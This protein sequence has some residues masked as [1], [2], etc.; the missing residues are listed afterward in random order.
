MFKSLFKWVAEPLSGYSGMVD[1][2]TPSITVHSIPRD[3]VFRPTRFAEYIG[4]TKA[5]P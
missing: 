4:Q 2:P 5:R 1:K 3:T